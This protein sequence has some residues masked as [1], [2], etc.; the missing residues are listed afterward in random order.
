MAASGIILCECQSTACTVSTAASPCLNT[1][2]MPGAKI[3]KDLK[4]RIFE[5]T[6]VVYFLSAFEFEPL[7]TVFT[8]SFF[9]AAWVKNLQVS[10]A[11]FRVSCKNQ[12][13]KK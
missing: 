13:T 7:S 8:I 10:K 5:R 4:I 3:I 1:S 12:D 6:S 2:Y 9:A 11:S